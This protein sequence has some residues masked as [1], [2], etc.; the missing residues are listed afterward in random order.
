MPPVWAAA[1]AK[2]VE[3][4]EFLTGTAIK[5]VEM[6]ADEAPAS[7]ISA[8]RPGDR[9]AAA[10]LMGATVRR[11]VPQGELITQDDV[12]YPGNPGFLAAVLSPGKRAVSIPTSAVSSNSGLVS[13]GDWVDVILTL[14]RETAEAMA[15]QQDKTS[16]MT[17]LAAQTILT[18]V[19]VLALNN[20]TESIAPQPETAPQR[21]DAKKTA[22]TAA[23]RADYRTITL[24]VTPMEAQALAVAKEAGDL[25]V[26]IRGL[27][28]PE[29]KD[30]AGTS[31]VN[32]KAA[33][34]THL[35]DATGILGTQ[36][37]AA[38]TV[39]TYQGAAV[40]PVTF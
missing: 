14:K 17:K 22:S 29:T 33:A 3:P 7:A 34:V 11:S 9:T 16:G 1:A 28:E 4:G 15:D 5:W 12:L 40:A 36:R 23:R 25:Q 6:K 2:P 13:A 18:N 26:S 30:A 21:T 10:L 38:K 20:S 19:R 27:R 8:K 37:P 24:E 31:A 39:I 35:Q 32:E